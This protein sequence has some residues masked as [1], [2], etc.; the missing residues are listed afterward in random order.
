MSM[1]SKIKSLLL[2]VGTAGAIISAVAYIATILVLVVGFEKQME[3]NQI[4]TIAVLGAVA[5]LSITVM[6]RSQGV[7]FAKAE[8]GSK[9]IMKE[10]YKSI[11]RHKKRK[12][13][14]TIKWHVTWSTI[15]DIVFKASSVAASTFFA[16][17]IFIDGS[18]DFGL[19]GLAAA[20]LSMFTCFGILSMSKAYDYY[21]E[22]HLEAIKELTKQNNETRPASIP[23]KGESNAKISNI[24]ETSTEE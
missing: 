23:A 19:L 18:G 21:L 10:Y 22:E 7:A 11:N 20:N 15:K 6:L 5:G 13:L 14:H 4:I 2:W 9:E 17:Y 12:S 16:I 1:T 24:T 3:L 8:P